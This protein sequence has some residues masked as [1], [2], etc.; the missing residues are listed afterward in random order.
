MSKKSLYIFSSKCKE[1][2]NDLLIVL[3]EY[4]SQIKVIQYIQY[5]FCILFCFNEES[6]RMAGKSS[7]KNWFCKF[8]WGGELKMIGLLLL[9]N[10]FSVSEY[11][12]KIKKMLMFEHVPTE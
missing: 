11:T 3:V 7:V 5:P 12:L 4:D 10:F 8:K 6:H 1:T 2:I 9:I